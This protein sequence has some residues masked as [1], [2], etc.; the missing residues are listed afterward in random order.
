MKKFSLRLT[1]I[2]L[3]AAMLSSCFSKPPEEDETTELPP[4]TTVSSIDPETGEPI[5]ILPSET[6]VLSL[7]PQSVSGNYVKTDSTFRVKTREDLEPSEL[8]ALLSVQPA[9]ELRVTKNA[10][11]DYTLDCGALPKGEIVKVLL[12]DGYGN[13]VNSWGFQTE[14]EFRVLSTVPADLST[15]V[16]PETGIEISLTA[17]ADLSKVSDYFEV[18]PSVSGTFTN[19][20]TTL[21]FVPSETLKKNTI[22]TVRVKAGLPSADGTALAEETVFSFRTSEGDDSDFCYALNGITESYLPDDP[23]VMDMSHSFSFLKQEFDLKLYRYPDSAAYRRAIEEYNAGTDWDGEYILPTEGLSLILDEKTTLQHSSV[24]DRYNYGYAKKSAFVLPDHLEEGWYLADL[25]TELDGVEYRIQRLIQISPI[26]VYSAVLSGQAMFFLN[27]CAT[28]GAA[29]NAEISLTAD[30]NEFTAK[31]DADGVALLDYSTD[32][33][34]YGILEIRYGDRVFCDR[35]TCVPDRELTPAEKYYM[36]LFTDRSA[37]LTTDTVRFWGVIAP[38]AEGTS[39]PSELTVKLGSTK[40]DGYSTAVTVSADGTFTGELHFERYVDRW[41]EP[42]TMFDGETELFSAYVSIKDYEKPLYVMEPVLPETVWMPQENGITAGVRLSYYDG[43]PA[44]GKTVMID[45]AETDQPTD[46]NGYA[47]RTILNPDDFYESASRPWQWCNPWYQLGGIEDNYRSAYGYVVGF[48]RDVGLDVE[49]VQAEDGS[50][51]LSLNAYH[52]KFVE[53]L[54]AFGGINDYYSGPFK[55]AYTGAPADLTVTASIKRSWYVKVEDGSYY[56]YVQKKQFTNYRYEEKT[57]QVGTYT[58]EVR[59]GI[60]AFDNLPTTDPD[61][62]YRITLTWDDSG[63]RPMSDDIHVSNTSFN[64]WNI[65]DQL[66]Y[67]LDYKEEYETPYSA[68][69]GETRSYTLTESYNKVTDFTGRIFY[70]IHRDRTLLTGVTDRNEFTVTMREEYIPNVDLI[71]AYFDGKHVFPIDYS[72]T[73]SF[74]RKGREIAVEIETDQSSYAPAETAQVRLTAKTTAGKTIPNARILLSVVDEAAFAIADQNADPLGTLY[75]YVY[76]P[77]AISY[78]SYI[79]HTMYDQNPGDGG[80]G[81][82]DE[83]IR[84]KFLDTAFFAEGITDANGTLTL[85]V[86]LPDNVTSWRF[87]AVAVAKYD[88]GRIYAGTQRLNV[89]AT[90]PVFVT[91]IMITEYVEGDDIVFSAGCAGDPSAKITAQ[92][93]GE[94]LSK[95]LS[96]DAD[97]EFDFGKLPIGEYTVL[98]RAE[99]DRGNDAAE[100][101]FRVVG[102]RLTSRIER[103]F[104]LGE[105]ID[106]SPAAWPVTL[107]FYNKDASLY[108]EILNTLLCTNGTNLDYRLAREYAA[109]ERGWGSAE[110]FSQTVRAKTANGRASIYSYTNSDYELT[111]LLCAAFPNEVDRSA[112]QNT[113][114]SCLTENYC[115]TRDEVVSCYLGLAALNRPVLNE[116]RNFLAEDKAL[117]AG[118]KLKLCA[119]LALLGDRETA[120]KY[121]LEI[122]ENLVLYQK[123]GEVYAYFSERNSENSD[124][125]QG[126]TRLALL[127]A[128]VLNLPEAESMA[129]WINRQKHREYG[130][131]LERVVFLKYYKP[132]LNLSATLG[133]T[134]NGEEKTEEINNFYGISLSFGEEQ[135]KNADFR[136]VSGNI[137]CSAIYEGKSDELSGTPTLTITKTITRM[138]GT[139]AGKAGAVYRVELSVEGEGEYFTIE[140]M[141]PSNARFLYA[142]NKSSGSKFVAVSNDDGQQD[143]TITMNNL[144]SATATYYIRQVTKGEAVLEGAVVYNSEGDYGIAEKDIFNQN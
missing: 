108:A 52:V 59:N 76:Y 68:E 40:N 74:N 120:L 133:Y 23:V 19:Y 134:V 51:T 85:S 89:S 11:C 49:D 38:R 22:Y 136:A 129:C 84:R 79:Q 140:D 28:G 94:G 16:L 42:L 48:I 122:T 111:A 44:V 15:Y 125:I 65:T 29:A 77:D 118:E 13:T 55:E 92:V 96:A 24:R 26:S 61:S 101:P 64:P 82:G 39:V 7:E 121:Y 57:E 8:S 56:D 109:V 104:D 53:N 25:V 126:D 88:G 30:E 14:D 45:N 4:I 100:Y 99:S 138:A 46:E 21:V 142:E 81:G 62:R 127:T 54:E 33:S 135:F 60:G 87:T 107:N 91:P 80:G 113:L 93:D 97:G 130:C 114:Q 103:G 37:Y 34:H 18:T 90:L 139:E 50:T 132:A 124:E 1:A 128:S 143:V 116:I 110:V 58:T 41:W 75:K 35:L 119:G 141:I 69:I 2:L 17:Q 117:T 9:R 102:A 144:R 66:S 47:E 20:S 123:D 95:T 98:F 71:A 27:D 83:P 86:E 73:L 5:R 115:E 10:A 67:G 32:E 106:L 70:A 43:T 6:A 63:G 131:A 112:V 78:A 12:G 72:R 137:G 31:T 36:Y 105:T 3:S